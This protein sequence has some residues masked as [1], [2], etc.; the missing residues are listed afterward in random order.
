MKGTYAVLE[1]PLVQRK[2]NDMKILLCALN[3]KYIHSNLAVHLLQAYV[4]N[5]SEYASLPEKIKPEI[6]VA[7]YTIN[8]QMED[9]LADIYLKKPDVA[10]FSCYIWNWEYT[11]S[12]IRDLH[13]VLPDTDIWVGGPEV[14]FDACKVLQENQ[15]I[16]GVMRGEGEGTFA[17]LAISYYSIGLKVLDEIDGITVR[18]ENGMLTTPERELLNM[19]NVPFIYNNDNIHEFDNKIIYYETSRG[20]P[21]SCSYCLSSVDRRVRFRSLGKVYDE[22]QFFLDHNVLQVKFVDRTFN[23]DHKHSMG[24]LTYIKEH[25]NGITNFHFEIAGDI[26]T[27]DEL[28]IMSE[29]RPGL[30]QLE[31]GVQSVNPDTI[32]AINRV[33]NLDKLKQTVSRINGM[34]NTHQH[35]DL[36]A[37]LPYENYE[38]FKVS[39]NEVYAMKPSQLQLGFLKVLKGAPMH[40][41]AENYGI[42]YKSNTPYEVLKTDWLAYDEILRLKKTEEMVE[43]YYNSHQF[44]QT[45]KVLENAFDSAFDMFLQ[46]ADFYDENGY[47]TNSPARIYR[48]NVLLSFAQIKDS[49]HE[50]LYKELLTYDLYLR[51]NLKSRPSFAADLAPYKEIIREMKL[52]KKLHIDAF[53]YNVW[54][55]SAHKIMSEN[56]E[57][58]FIAFDYERRD[59]L[60]N[61]AFVIQL[62]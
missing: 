48:Y 24:I 50:V 62:R 4:L 29:M 16:L 11:R 26:L 59:P 30:I 45:I 41:S 54:E 34:K 22:L 21:F 1:V 25:D 28:D 7:E 12:I 17:E 23:I 56:D 18:T 57:I 32:K 55:E 10:A 61:N 38:S 13:K 36:I 8:N 9:I 51:E 20:C 52:D 60:Y 58:T 37:G 27:E 43:L 49:A 31:I 44:S 46:L 19:D 47:F 39:F 3:S 2:S 15:D 53:K 33:M 14:T 6:E 5:S 35:L 42:V 40:G